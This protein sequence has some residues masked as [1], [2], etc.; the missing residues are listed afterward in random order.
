[1]GHGLIL[2]SDPLTHDDEI[3]AQY[4][5]QF[6]CS[7]FFVDMLRNCSFT[8]LVLSFSPTRK[9]RC[10]G[11]QLLRNFGVFAQP[12]NFCHGAQL[13]RNFGWFRAVLALKI[14]HFGEI[15]GQIGP[16]STD[17]LSFPKHVAICPKIATSCLHTFFQ[18]RCHWARVARLMKL[19]HS[20]YS[21]AYRCRE[22]RLC[23]Q[24]YLTFALH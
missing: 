17:N 19:R 2:Y 22:Q 16:L 7:Y 3:T 4:S 14:F 21:I 23:F 12:R 24:R 10:C 5:L 15:W 18:C 8:R 1:M 20:L 9:L 6:F 11:A 13:S